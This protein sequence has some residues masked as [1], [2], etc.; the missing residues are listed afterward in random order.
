MHIYCQY[1]EK[2][3]NGNI[4]FKTLEGSMCSVKTV[5]PIGSVKWHTLHTYT[6]C[7]TSHITNFPALTLI[8]GYAEN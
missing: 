3:I 2:A 7:S 1:T 5:L 4:K 6:L 8:A